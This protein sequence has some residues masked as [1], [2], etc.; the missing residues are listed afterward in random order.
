MKKFLS[1]CF[2]FA[3]VIPA[4]FL[5][6]ACGSTTYS[7]TTESQNA[8]ITLQTNEAKKGDTI[9]FDVVVDESTEDYLYKLERVYYVVEAVNNKMC[10]QVK[11]QPTLSQCQKAMLLFMHK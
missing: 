7:L 9:I 1:L 11:L 2:A 8:T 3:L 5:L 10:L 6:S 4:M